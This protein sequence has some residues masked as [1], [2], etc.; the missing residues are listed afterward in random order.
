[1]IYARTESKLMAFSWGKKKSKISKVHG[2]E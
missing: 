1:M 2:H